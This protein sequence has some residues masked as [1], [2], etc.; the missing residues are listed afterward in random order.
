MNTHEQRIVIM[1][2]NGAGK[3]R[4]ANRLA[5]TKAIPALELDLFSWQSGS[6]PRI[7]PFGLRRSL[8]DIFMR[9]NSQWIIEGDTADVLSVAIQKAT[10]LIFL[11]PT[12]ELRRERAKAAQWR[13]EIFATQECQKNYLTT[14]INILDQ[15]ETNTD[16]IH[17]L[18]AHSRLYEHFT[19]RKWEIYESSSIEKHQIRDAHG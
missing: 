4:F 6:Q 18:S 11:R 19:G 10:T 2:C 13:P 15:Y 16:P 3:T 14:F 8:T 5:Q 1:G 9:K 7:R 12:P 17:S